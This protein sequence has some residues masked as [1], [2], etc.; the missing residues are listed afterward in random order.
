METGGA[1]MTTTASA[2]ATN[3]AYAELAQRVAGTTLAVLPDGE[4][5][6]AVGL[7]PGHPAGTK[8]FFAT[9]KNATE[10]VQNMMWDAPQGVSAYQ[11]AHGVAILKQDGRFAAVA[12][13]HSLLGVLQ[14][15]DGNLGVQ[16][17]AA[18]PVDGANTPR[19][20]KLLTGSGEILSD[21]TPRVAGTPIGSVDI[22]RPFVL[23][24]PT[25]GGSTINDAA[26]GAL[27]F[28]RSHKV[29][30]GVGAGIAVAGAAVGTWYLA[31]AS[32]RK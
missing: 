21:A 2:A 23:D 22:A 4:Q 13:D 10:F 9:A 30:V 5:V 3:P 25:L 1:G 27:E 8:P 19:V 20:E 14:L 15:E 17:L 18:R 7:L 12:L 29:G 16:S 32:S 6:H 28:I 24:S 31:S 11:P 26:G